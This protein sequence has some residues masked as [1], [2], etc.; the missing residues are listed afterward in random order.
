MSHTIAAAQP[1]ESFSH[2]IEKSWG[3]IYL[4]PRSLKMDTYGIL[5]QAVQALKA[6]ICAFSAASQIPL[7]LWS[8]PSSISYLNNKNIDRLLE[9]FKA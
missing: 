8:L 7:Q 2:N 3:M 5:H 1:L 4:R 9:E 6:H